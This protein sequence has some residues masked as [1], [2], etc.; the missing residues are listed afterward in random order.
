MRNNF[1]LSLFFLIIIGITSINPQLL[2][3]NFEYGLS[4]NDLPTASTS[5]WSNHS[6]GTTINDVQ[7]STS[8]LS[9]SG[10]ASSGIGGSTSLSSSRTGDDSRTFTSQ[11]SGSIYLSALVNIISITSGT[12]G[13]YF[14]HFGN[15]GTHYARLYAKDVSGSLRFGL[16]KAAETPTFSSNNYSFNTTYLII[17][18]YT[19]NGSSQDD[20]V[21]L[22]I[23]SSGVP[24][25]ESNAGTP[26][27]ENV[28]FANTDASSISTVSV[29][30]GTSSH[31]I[32]VDGIR[33]SSSWN[34]APLPVEFSTFTATFNNKFVN[35]NWITQTEVNNYGFEVER[36]SKSLNNDWQKIGFVQGNGNSNS[37]NRYS[38]VDKNPPVNKLM[39]RLK[40][41]DNDG[42]FSYSGVVEV[43][44]ESPNKF[45]LKQ[46]YPNPFALKSDLTPNGNTSTRLT[47]SIPIDGFVKLTLYNIVGQ[48]IM[49][50]ENGFKN[51][52][53]YS[54]DFKPFG[55]QSGVFFCSLESNGSKQIIKM[56]LQK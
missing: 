44:F 24:T 20:R 53:S 48:E 12:N 32:S 21:D 37:I 4:S 10:Y 49:I 42:G 30:Q 22:W 11:T 27:V 7:F 45:E 2:V 43:D 34:E 55:L 29:R 5:N 54:M 52:G 14:L 1:K 19:F 47:Y 40:Q 28:T 46:N 25:S 15:T 13:E 35:L 18:K 17:I 6:G 3:D 50:L 33:I 8:G 26:T 23:I 41:I 56:I 39:Y 38:F 31:N 36:F 51:A 16:S 9:Y